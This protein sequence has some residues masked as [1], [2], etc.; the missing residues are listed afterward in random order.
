[1]KKALG[2]A[3]SALLIPVLPLMAQEAE[4]AHGGG[5]LDIEPGLM[6]WTV[7]VFLIL[8]FV[9]WKAAWPQILGAVEARERRLEEQI[10]ET[11]RNR[12]ESLRI[13]EEHRQLLAE[14]RGQ[15][16][17]VLA[18]ARAA[19]DRERAAAVE[20]TKAEQA[21][22]LERARR[23]IR[24][25]RERAIADLRREAVDLSIAAASRLIEKRLDSETDRKLV[26]EYLSTLEVGR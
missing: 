9:L 13:L 25:E 5:P 12:A 6:I 16:Q 4:A 23:E 8:L 26:A 15:A 10:A 11:E 1:M 19:A 20:R 2:L 7:L 14:A 17:H 22:L 3:V 18:E 24:S 21:E